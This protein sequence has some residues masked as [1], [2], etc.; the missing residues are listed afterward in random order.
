[1]AVTATTF[2]APAEWVMSKASFTASVAY[3]CPRADSIKP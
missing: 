2:R 1:M 3:P